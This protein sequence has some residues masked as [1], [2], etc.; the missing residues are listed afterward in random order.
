MGSTNDQLRSEQ[1]RV[2]LAQLDEEVKQYVDTI[3]ALKNENSELKNRVELSETQSSDLQERL[4]IRTDQVEELRANL[5]DC[6]SSAQ[7]ASSGM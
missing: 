2:Q 1:A 5:S 3:N 4:A 7:I 6:G